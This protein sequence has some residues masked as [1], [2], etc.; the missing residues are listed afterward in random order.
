MISKI[1]Q[2]YLLEDTVVGTIVHNLT[3]SNSLPRQYELSIE[4]NSFKVTNKLMKNVFRPMVTQFFE[5]K[6]LKQFHRFV[7]FRIHLCC[8][9]MAVYN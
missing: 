8:Y 5:V 7:F 6:V 3:F 1:I 2:F 4:R 9:K